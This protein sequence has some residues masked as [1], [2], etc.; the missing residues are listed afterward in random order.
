MPPKSKLTKEAICESA[1]KFV[2]T[3]GI[4]ALNA[5][6]LTT[7]LGCSTQPLFTHY[8]SMEELKK[9]VSHASYRR[10]LTYL[11]TA[12]TDPSIPPYKASG[13]A[14]LRFAKEE[15]LL[16]Q[17][18]F[19]RKRAAEEQKEVGLEWGSIISMIKKKTGLSQ[20]EAERFHM[21]M[22]VYTHG[23]ASMLATGFLELDETT[24]SKMLS[25]HYRRLRSDFCK[26]AQE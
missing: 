12:A 14:Y 13:L 16:F 25:D 8:K 10:Y 17:L 2:S 24:V 23:I 11:N 6:S 20:E 15:P 5:R 9:D 1:L 18:N 4:Q 22:W 7:L 3:Q 21:E 19:M 26:E